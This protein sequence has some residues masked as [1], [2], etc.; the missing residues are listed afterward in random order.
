MIQGLG[1]LGSR[2]AWEP[3]EVCVCTR[4]LHGRETPVDEWEG[5]GK[6]RGGYYLKGTIRGKERITVF[7]ISFFF[8]FP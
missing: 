3:G 1:V 8:S 7:G 5:E 4:S 6:G 2:L